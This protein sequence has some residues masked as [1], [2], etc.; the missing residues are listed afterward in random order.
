MQSEAKRQTT[1][2]RGCRMMT[3]ARVKCSLKSKTA[4][5]IRQEAEPSGH[6]CNREMVNFHT[7]AV[8]GCTEKVHP[9][10]R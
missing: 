10:C 7:P 6:H 8:E 3:W 1:A 5:R 4:T 2:R 9:T